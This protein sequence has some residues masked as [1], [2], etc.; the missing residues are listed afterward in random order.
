VSRLI[1]WNEVPIDD[2]AEDLI[3]AH[4]VLINS[5]SLRRADYRGSDKAAVVEI[6]L[7]FIPGLIAQRD[8][9]QRSHH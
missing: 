2:V 8:A 9:R 1:L 7:E 5:Q 6:K 3:D 4:A